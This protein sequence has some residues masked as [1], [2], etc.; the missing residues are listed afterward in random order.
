MQTIYK[1]SLLTVYHVNLPGCIE[2]VA[3]KGLAASGGEF[4]GGLGT[5]RVY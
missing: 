5:V 4:K 3:R 2:R 1:F